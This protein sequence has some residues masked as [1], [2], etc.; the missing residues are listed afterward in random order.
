MHLKTEPNAD[1]TLCTL[2][3]TT[4]SVFQGEESGSAILDASHAVARVPDRALARQVTAAAPAWEPR[5]CV[6]SARLRQN[7]GMRKSA[8]AALPRV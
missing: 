3:R 8:S 6:I 5:L 4:A 1:R 2:T 7:T